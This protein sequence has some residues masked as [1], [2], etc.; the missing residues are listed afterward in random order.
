MRRI[1][2]SVVVQFAF[3]SASACAARRGRCARDKTNLGCTMRST[4]LSFPVE[5]SL[6]GA[7]PAVE[8]CG[9]LVGGDRWLKA[10][11]EGPVLGDFGGVLPEAD[12][13]A[14]EVGRA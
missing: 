2:L 6:D 12:G 13:K 9:A 14:G 1:A 8:F 5:C 7:L 4:L 10:A 3:R 11:V